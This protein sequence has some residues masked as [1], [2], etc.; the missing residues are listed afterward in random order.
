MAKAAL[1][2][3]QFKR[4]LDGDR[5]PESCAPALRALWHDAKGNS[6]R[7]FKIACNFND[8]DSARVRAYLHRKREESTQAKIWYWKAGVKLADG[9]LADEWQD[10]VR[11]ILTQDIIMSAYEF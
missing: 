4:S 2:F 9:D 3:D 10:I 8:N 1:E 6:E 11:T 7:A 5:P